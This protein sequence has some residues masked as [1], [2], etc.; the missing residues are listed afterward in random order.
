MHLSF[1]NLN[2]VDE[3]NILSLVCTFSAAAVSAQ[4]PS[5]SLKIVSGS[6]G[7]YQKE[8]KLSEL[9]TVTNFTNALSIG[10]TGIQTTASGA[11]GT[12]A[13][14]A[15]RGYSNRHYE[16]S[17]VVFLDGLPYWGALN[18]INPATIERID[19][20][21]NG[22]D[23]SAPINF[24]ADGVIEIF[25]KKASLA[26]AP[27]KVSLDAN[28]GVNTRAVPEYDLVTDPAQFYEIRHQLWRSSFYRSMGDWNAAGQAANAYIVS[29]DIKNLYDVPSQA[30]VDPVSGK[31]NPDAR[32]RYQDKAKEI[33]QRIGLR[34]AY[35]LEASKMYKNAGLAFNAGY[36]KENSYLKNSDFNRFNVGANAFWNAG[37]KLTLGLN[38]YFANTGGQF[39]EPAFGDR[40]TYID[41]FQFMRITGPAHSIYERDQEGNMVNDPNT[42]QPMPTFW[43]RQ[44][45]WFLKNKRASNNNMLRLHPSVKYRL[46]EQ[47]SLS[48]LG[49]YTTNALKRTELNNVGL[50]VGGTV[51][52]LPVG[53]IVA[54]S[55]SH[56]ISLNPK[57][58]FEKQ[59]GAHH[60]TGF[61][62]YM[63]EA[64]SQRAKAYYESAFYLPFPHMLPWQGT[65]YNIWNQVHMVDGKG[66]YSYNDR[67]NLTARINYTN[68][69]YRN[70]DRNQ[71]SLNPG[72]RSRSNVNYAFRAA[73][74]AGRDRWGLWADVAQTSN[75][76]RTSS[77]RTLSIVYNHFY[78]S[79]FPD[80]SW[81]FE[82]E[83]VPRQTTFDL[84]AYAHVGGRLVVKGTLYARQ[85]KN[86]VD[87][88][89]TIPTGWPMNKASDGF[90]IMNR[91]AELQVTY[92][93]VQ[94]SQFRWETGI[95]ATHT[96]ATIQDLK[97]SLIG[98]GTNTIVHDKGN[99]LNSFYA[100]RMVGVDPNDGGPIYAYKNG[101]TKS[102][103]DLVFSDYVKMGSASPFLYG[104]WVNN[105]SAGKFSFRMAWNFALGGKVY[106]WDYSNSMNTG[107][108]KQGNFH[109]DVADSWTPNNREAS[110]P[111]MAGFYSG[112]YSDFY[113][114]SG[115]WLSLKSLMLNYSIPLN[116]LGK[117][118][119]QALNIYAA[120]EN[121]LFFS[122]RKGLNPNAN[123]IG[124]ASNHYVPMRTVMLGVKI[125]F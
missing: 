96:K 54:N 42:G 83:Y 49:S 8:K 27:W 89:P 112:A 73:W 101:T 67:F 79:S 48:V 104:S 98:R 25:T 118:G 59:S 31:F 80:D 60:W 18:A 26:P 4:E 39:W 23:M 97:F 75:Y 84:G 32:L 93:P 124:D 122:A 71:S 99:E 7:T 109:K 119:Y 11:P 106:D 28:V 70:L 51:P 53:L 33:I 61:V 52:Q 44:L 110:I 30:L 108:W 123:F 86:S 91:G 43:G 66:G 76:L 55:N 19:V 121:I 95:Y 3:K 15:I 78:K 62:Q 120:G 114:T 14:I 50:A 116:W 69:R 111:V 82:N 81:V 90:N 5:D 20:H 41:P 94:N 24:A 37:E 113:V 9:S 10:T 88:L 107:V 117:S 65:E 1:I 38:A 17:P 45:S 22:I 74:K 115:S 29:Q 47:F 58:D 2:D 40:N 63:Y 87:I 6:R 36:L 35:N 72:P 77:E 103:N 125:D 34:H 85:I 68:N 16:Q 100:P 12:N 102:Y 92:R 57:L 64:V 21:K 56:D 105:V 13:G 46:N